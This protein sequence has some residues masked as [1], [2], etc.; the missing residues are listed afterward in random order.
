MTGA[1]YLCRTGVAIRRI[2]GVTSDMKYKNM[3]RFSYSGVAITGGTG[4]LNSSLGGS[5]LM[6]NGVVRNY[7]TPTN[8]Q[9][10]DQIEYRALF[11]F[12]TQSWEDLTEG[13]RTEWENARSENG[14]QVQD[15]FTGTS[16]PASS[17]KALFISV[18][19]NMA[20]AGNTTNAPAVLAQSPPSLEPLEVVSISSVVVDASA[21]TVAL[22]YTGA[23]TN[24]AI[25]SRM[26]KP[27]SAGNMR[28]TSVK[29]DLRTLPA[30][31]AVSPQ[32]LGGAYVA[33]FG[34]ITEDGGRKVFYFMEG[35][36]PL[37]GTRRVLAS[38]NVVIVP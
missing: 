12:L 10:E 26:T 23:L 36:N 20:I 17:G 34:A 14:R 28:L 16:R 30:S 4:R 29:S 11:A 33:K 24:M 18:N 3:A 21:G 22:T 31:G 27:V 37:D 6:K 32:A 2:D 25:V 19:T 8:P 9:T 7:V 38:G 5:V 15:P 35:I 13:E 1:S